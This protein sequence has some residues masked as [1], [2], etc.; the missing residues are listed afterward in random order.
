MPKDPH[1]RWKV[2]D[3]LREL[4][5]IITKNIITKVLLGFMFA[6]V[7]TYAANSITFIGFSPT[8]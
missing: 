1:M 6:L 2:G 7:N 3:L 8:P 4:K 5:H